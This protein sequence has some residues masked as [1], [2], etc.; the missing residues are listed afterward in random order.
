MQQALVKIM[1]NAVEALGPRGRIILQTK[2]LDL[3]QPT[4]DRNAQ[5]AAGSYVCA[6]ITDNG[7]GIEAEVLPRIFEPFFTTKRGRQTPRAW[8]WRGFMAS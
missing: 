8:G 3:T 5:L 2:N 4:Q 1:E 6:E 7:C